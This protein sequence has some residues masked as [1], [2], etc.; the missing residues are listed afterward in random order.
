ML[1]ISDLLHTYFSLLLDYQVNLEVSCVSFKPAN[2][3]NSASINCSVMWLL[4]KLIAAQ[5]QRA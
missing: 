5:T 3:S 4:R 1:L 2:S